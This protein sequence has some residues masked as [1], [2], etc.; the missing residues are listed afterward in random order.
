MHHPHPPL[1]HISK[2]L[3]HGKKTNGLENHNSVAITT[4][5]KKDKKT[6]EC[7]KILWLT[8]TDVCTHVFFMKMGM[9]AHVFS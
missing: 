1:N 5:F 3:S 9:H 7:N 2:A 8:S 4:R 6:S